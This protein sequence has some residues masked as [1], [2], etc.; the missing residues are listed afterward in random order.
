M[1]QMSS[2]FNHD[3]FNDWLAESQKVLDEN[4]EAMAKV[5]P[6]RRPGE[7]GSVAITPLYREWFGDELPPDDA[8]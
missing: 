1:A 6:I 8:A 7:I 3:S 2:R 4:E 5:V